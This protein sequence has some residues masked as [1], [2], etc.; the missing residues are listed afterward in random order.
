VA[1]TDVIFHIKAIRFSI[2]FIESGQ[3]FAVCI[4]KVVGFVI[5]KITKAIESARGA[6]ESLKVS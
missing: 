1:T 6:N 3:F 4:P 2:K 5:G